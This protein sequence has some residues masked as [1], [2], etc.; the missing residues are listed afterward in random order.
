ATA[1]IATTRV[2]ARSLRRSNLGGVRSLVS[3]VIHGAVTPPRLLRR[4]LLAMTGLGVI[5]SVSLSCMIIP[6]HC[7]KTIAAL[8][9]TR[10]QLQEHRLQV[11][12]PL[13]HGVKLIPLRAQAF[14]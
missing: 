3:G 8:Y 10:R 12:L 2:I 11:L 5:F 7:S 1:A 9:R 14:H 4:G 6:F 13:L